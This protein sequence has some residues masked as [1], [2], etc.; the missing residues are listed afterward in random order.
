MEYN[1]ILFK[2]CTSLSENGIIVFLICIWVAFLFTMSEMLFAQEENIYSS[3]C[4]FFY[5]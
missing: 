3:V 5:H 4:E 1:V 2:I